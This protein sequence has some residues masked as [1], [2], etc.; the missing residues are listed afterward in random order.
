MSKNDKDK[1]AVLPKAPDG[2]VCQIDLYR[3][4]ITQRDFVFPKTSENAG[5]ENP[6]HTFTIGRRDFIFPEKTCKP[7]EGFSTEFLYGH[8]IEDLTELSTPLSFQPKFYLGHEISFP[9]FTSFPDLDFTY[10]HYIEWENTYTTID[11]N[12]FFYGHTIEQLTSFG[13]VEFPRTTFPYGHTLTLTELTVNSWLSKSPIEI[14]HGHTVLSTIGKPIVLPEINSYYGFELENIASL[15]GFPTTDFFFG[16]SLSS[17]LNYS[18]DGVSV[19]LE[20]IGEGFY[21]RNLYELHTGQKDIRLVP[22]PM[23][24]ANFIVSCSFNGTEETFFDRLQPCCYSD[25]KLWGGNDFYWELN[26]KL[27]PNEEQGFNVGWHMEVELHTRTNLEIEFFYG[28]HFNPNEELVWKWDVYCY[29]GHSVNTNFAQINPINLCGHSTI[30]DGS[31]VNIELLNEYDASCIHYS[32]S[33]GHNLQ[34]ILSYTDGLEA[35][36]YYGHEIEVAAHVDRWEIDFYWGFSL[37]VFPS[38]SVY[39][40]ADCYYGKDVLATFYIPP[41]NLYYGHEATGEIT[42]KYYV[43]FTEY[44]CLENEYIY[45]DENHIRRDFLTIKDPVEFLPFLHDIKARCF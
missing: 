15:S 20:P 38:F 16:H 24:A 13:R 11:P 44:G 23:G 43:E 32:M 10:S 7:V 5:S 31:N 42:L 25:N 36:C 28:H 39:L 1:K 2:F 26:K 19:N 8:T 41:I 18:P 21:L 37:E 6:Y 29:Y 45:T 4:W 14:G 12:D 3:K 22:Y 27:Y 33:Y 30:I 35:D 40:D 9:R 17:V 34:I